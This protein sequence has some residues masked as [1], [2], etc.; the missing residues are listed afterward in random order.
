M[1]D[2]RALC[3][4]WVGSC[5]PRVATGRSYVDEVGR[6]VMI[7]TRQSSGN[8]VTI[9]AKEGGLEGVV[10]F[11]QDSR[12]GVCDLDNERIYI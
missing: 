7:V 8:F 4:F 10:V 3:C 5:S 1:G 2:Y 11:E 12:I 9:C 6:L